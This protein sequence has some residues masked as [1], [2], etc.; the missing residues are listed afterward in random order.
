MT[1]P[2]TLT[3]T[4]TSINAANLAVGALLNGGQLRALSATGT[5]LAM[6]T[7]ANPAWQMNEAGTGVRLTLG[8][9]STVASGTAAYVECWTAGGDKVL[10]APAVESLAPVSGSVALNT[11]TFVAGATLLSAILVLE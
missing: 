3:W 1:V 10:S 7:F 9:G 4:Q 2:T 11:L 8:V 6:G 5:L